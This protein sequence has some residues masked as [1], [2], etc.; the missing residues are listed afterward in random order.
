M[1]MFE[2]FPYTDMHNLNLDWI[3][4]IAKDFLDQYTHIQQLISDGETS[5]QNLTTEG[6]QQ[7]QDMAENLENLLQ[8]WYDTHSQDIAN[9]LADALSDL[10]EWY[11]THQGYL[12]QYVQDSITLFQTTAAQKAA[13]TIAT[14]PDDYTSFYNEAI[15]FGNSYFNT[16]TPPFLDAN[17][18]PKNTVFEF[19]GL[20]TPIANMPTDTAL[21]NASG[22]FIYCEKNPVWGFQIYT[23]ID[24]PTYGYYRTKV[25][26]SWG[27]WQPLVSLTNN[28][29]DIKFYGTFFNTD[30]APFN[31]AN[32]AP[33]NSK[34]E[35]WGLSTS[36][37]HM[38]F[39]N[40]PSEPVIL[41][42]YALG[43]VWEY[44][45]LTYVSDPAYGFYRHKILSNWETTWHEME[46]KYHLIRNIIVQKNNAN[47]D[48]QSLSKAI[49]EIYSSGLRNVTIHIN[50]GE[51]D[52]VSELTEIAQ[53][54]GKTLD[55]F[56]QDYEG[57]Q[58]GHGMHLI[59][60]PKADVHFNYTGSSYWVQAG[61]SAFDTEDGNCT[62]EGLHIHC[63]NIKYCVHDDLGWNVYT[64][65]KNVFNNCVMEII[66]STGNTLSANYCI[67]GGLGNEG[68]IIIN[69]GLYKAYDEN[70]PNAK[71]VGINYHN[72]QNANSKSYVQITNVYCR[73]KTT[74]GV[75]WH[76]TSTLITLAE[77]TNCNVY[78]NII[79]GPENEESTI[80]NIELIEW[81]N[82]KRN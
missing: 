75:T 71:T 69:G 74:L 34:Y 8:E 14:I 22:K 3:I 15:K 30:T 50:S 39:V 42:T 36:I 82:V 24:D 25:W 33:K 38:P 66:K 41:T 2:N 20:S 12:D 77:I 40:F 54:E 9:Q 27:S 16:D 49:R 43:D 1:A 60:S 23:K 19:W 57:L 11:N 70:N 6:L 13:E 62:I 52:L 44:Q 26:Q 21:L 81:N 53:E 68:T 64:P 63:E 76:G 78:D 65:Y 37:A 48:Y 58:V 17:N 28:E 47:A 67:G 80:Q 56:L 10:N 55:E 31:D 51:Y 73:D 29:K 79:Y 5:L 61:F 72:S 46:N 59:F 18:A 45:T 35:F 32:N 7:L 4:K